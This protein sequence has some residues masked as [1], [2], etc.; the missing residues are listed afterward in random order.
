MLNPRL[1][2]ARSHL[3]FRQAHAHAA[4]PRSTVID[5]WVQFRNVPT[6]ESWFIEGRKR[7]HDDENASLQDSPAL[8]ATLDT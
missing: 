1:G 3:C 8:P 5:L 6:G 7:S 4:G 2:Y